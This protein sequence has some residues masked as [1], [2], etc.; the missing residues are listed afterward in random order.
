MGG[1]RFEHLA[2][3]S[4]VSGEG[5]FQVDGLAGYLRSM[6]CQVQGF[7]SLCCAAA[8]GIPSILRRRGVF[9]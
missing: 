9:F 4:T 6:P 3:G 1:I 8:L 7:K 2:L 5:F